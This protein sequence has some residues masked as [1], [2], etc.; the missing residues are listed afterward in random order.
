MEFAVLMIA[1][2]TSAPVFFAFE[3]MILGVFPLGHPQFFFIVIP[4]LQHCLLTLQEL[5]K[6]TYKTC[7]SLL[8]L[9]FSTPAMFTT[10]EWLLQTNIPALLLRSV[11]SWV[12][13]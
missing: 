6:P 13:I 8:K 9:T 12:G 4:T 1:L 5:H 7:S 11:E 10:N 3:L 2:S